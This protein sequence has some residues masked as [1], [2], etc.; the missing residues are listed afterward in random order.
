MLIFTTSGGD[1]SGIKFDD[2]WKLHSN[3]F[4]TTRV[5]KINRVTNQANSLN[6]SIP[7]NQ[8]INKT[9]KKI[10]ELILEGQTKRLAE[11]EV[12]TAQKDS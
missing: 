12:D 6:I 2:W 7:L 11:L 5:E 4:G 8:P 10:K 9:L 1:V 3:L